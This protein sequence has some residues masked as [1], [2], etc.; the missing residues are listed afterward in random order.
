MA[1][2]A[3]L[4]VDKRFHVPNGSKGSYKQSS[5]G[6]KVGEEGLERSVS[7]LERV[8]SHVNNE[9]ETFDGGVESEDEEV[10][11]QRKGDLE[12]GVASK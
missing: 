1:S 2:F 8:M 4:R 6:E 10:V 5:T 11:R 9:E 3:V 12:A 7:G